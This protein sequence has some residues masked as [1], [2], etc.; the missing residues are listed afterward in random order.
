MALYTSITRLARQATLCQDSNRPDWDRQNFDDPRTSYLNYWIPW[1]DWTSA[2]RWNL[3]R[4]SGFGIASVELHNV[5]SNIL[6]YVSLFFL[7][8][9]ECTYNIRTIVGRT[10]YLN[11]II[12]FKCLYEQTLIISMK[13]ARWDCSFC[14]YKCLVNSLRI[15]YCR[16]LWHVCGFKVGYKLNYNL[17]LLDQ[18]NI[19]LAASKVILVYT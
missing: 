12:F 9:Y 14:P 16:F 1:V 7:S 19:F 3:Y 11:P 8:F 15:C 6:R 17:R 2:A 10:L 18:L 5:H 13:M 4:P